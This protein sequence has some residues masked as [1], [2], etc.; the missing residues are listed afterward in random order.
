MG[1]LMENVVAAL[2]M[3]HDWVPPV[4]VCVDRDPPIG[5]VFN[6]CADPVEL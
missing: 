3:G 6:V 4:K 5:K 2:P 1:P